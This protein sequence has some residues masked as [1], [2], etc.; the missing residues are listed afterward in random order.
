MSEI[1]T[2]ALTA[3]LTEEEKDQAIAWL[4]SKSKSPVC[5]TCGESG[6]VV[7]NH[8]LALVSWDRKWSSPAVAIECRNCGKVEMFR[9]ISM[10]IDGPFGEDEDG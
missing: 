8:R 6:W 5:S 3:K 2:E 7:D 1:T 9:T 10:G 4:K